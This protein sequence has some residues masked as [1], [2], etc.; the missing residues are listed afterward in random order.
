LGNPCLRR[1]KRDSVKEN[2][3]I[4]NPRKMESFKGP[5]TIS[6]RKKFSFTKLVKVPN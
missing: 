4:V 3:M 1:R 5:L 6:K 2:K